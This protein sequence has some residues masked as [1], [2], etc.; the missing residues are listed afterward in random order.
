V[1]EQ[2]AWSALAAL[3]LG[4]GGGSALIAY[5]KDR[6]KNHADGQVAASTVELQI[7]AKRMAN[8]EQ[9]FVLAEKAWDAERD[10]LLG[11]NS[12]L[13]AELRDER[14]ESERKE[15]KMLAL[16]ERLGVLQAELQAMARELA[17]LRA[18]P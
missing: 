16:E 9:R 7:D 13:E 12:R 4:G 18:H 17:D 3:A 14:L 6:R 15:A 10:S 2:S 1:S 5:V 11:R 8:L